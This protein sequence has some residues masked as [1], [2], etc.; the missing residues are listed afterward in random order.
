MPDQ[1][2]K[3]FGSVNGHRHQVDD[4]DRKA[5]APDLVA[6]QPRKADSPNALIEIVVS[7]NRGARR[8][9]DMPLEKK[10]LRVTARSTGRAATT[11]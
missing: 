2:R 5:R 8:V 9:I 1:S 4:F 7:G 3:S 10:H 11:E 6:C